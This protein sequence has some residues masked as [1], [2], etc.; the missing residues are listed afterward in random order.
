MKRILNSKQE[1]LISK[2]ITIFKFQCLKYVIWDLRSQI[3]KD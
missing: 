2:Q 1:I 3:E